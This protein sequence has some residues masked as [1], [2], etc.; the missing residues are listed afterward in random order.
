[1]KS[2]DVFFIESTE[3]IGGQIMQFE[4]E[5]VESAGWKGKKRVILHLPN[6]EKTH[7][8]LRPSKNGYYFIAIN[9][10]ITERQGWQDGMRFK[11]ELEEDNSEYQMEAPEEFYEVL[12][13][14]PEGK[15]LFH[16]QT[17]GRQR[18]MLHFISSAKSSQLRIERTMMFIERMKETGYPFQSE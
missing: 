2:F 7:R 4:S 9:K 12:A 3:G 6:G 1:M 18:S 8:A 13:Q 11:V 5:Q 16:S 15:A 10:K 17:P 14:D